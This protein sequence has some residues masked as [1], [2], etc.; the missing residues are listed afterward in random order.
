M[1]NPKI[2]EVSVIGIPDKDFGEAIKAVCVLKQGDS[3][4]AKELVDFVAQRIARYKK[5]KYVEFVEKLPKTS[6]GNI[7]RE[8]VKE[9]YGRI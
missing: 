6:S 1:G 2:Q 8:K 9:S 5:P 4:E 7:D 3:M